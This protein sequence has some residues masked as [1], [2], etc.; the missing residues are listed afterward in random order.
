MQMGRPDS[1]MVLMN[2]RKQSNNQRLARL[3]DEAG[4][5]RA[6]ALVRF[7]AA[8]G[9]AGYSYEYWKGFFCDPTS[10]RYKP[11]R[12]DLLTHAEKIFSKSSTKG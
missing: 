11:L 12:D 1:M 10:Q 2:T 6:E 8:L 5:T 7:N 3:V 4:L 9:P